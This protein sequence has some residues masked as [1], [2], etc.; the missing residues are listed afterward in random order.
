[1]F[2]LS[3]TTSSG[4]YD[5]LL[6]EYSVCVS[7]IANNIIWAIESSRRTI[8]VLSPNYLES[9]FTRFEWQRAH[10]EML[11]L[12]HKV[13]PII[14]DDIADVRD[15]MDGTMKTILDSI[16]YIEWPGADNEKALRRFWKQLELSMPKKKYSE[17]PSGKAIDSAILSSKGKKTEI[18]SSETI[19]MDISKNFLADTCYI[20]TAFDASFGEQT[21]FDVPSVNGGVE[22]LDRSN[23]NGRMVGCDKIIETDISKKP[24]ERKPLD[25]NEEIKL[26]FSQSEKCD[27]YADIKRNAQELERQLEGENTTEV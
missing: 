10:T 15:N 20:S 5:S 6:T 17:E 13:V 14:L 16:T 26:F 9:E 1:M 2:Q 8:L 4:R 12:K 22:Q 7:A 21:K 11:K 27:A 19:D 25:R 23:Q 24:T 18:L 3:P